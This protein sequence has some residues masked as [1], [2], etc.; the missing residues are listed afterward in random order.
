MLVVA[1]TV[2]MH[3][4]VTVKNLLLELFP[5]GLRAALILADGVV[6]PAV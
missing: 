6:L 5:V 3:V 2:E 4:L 1:G